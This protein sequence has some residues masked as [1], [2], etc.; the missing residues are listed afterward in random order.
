[1]HR[2]SSAVAPKATGAK[3]GSKTSTV[4]RGFEKTDDWLRI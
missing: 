1:V 3:R 4:M 2:R